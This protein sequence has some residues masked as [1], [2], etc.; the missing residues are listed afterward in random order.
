MMAGGGGGTAVVE[1][2]DL[3]ITSSGI[4]GFEFLTT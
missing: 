2:E 4:G 1:V 3:E